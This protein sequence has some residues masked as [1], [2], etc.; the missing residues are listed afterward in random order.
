MGGQT[1]ANSYTVV[2]SYNV[3]VDKTQ[4]ASDMD[5][6]HSSDKTTVLVKSCDYLLFRHTI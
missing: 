6:S 2:N 5:S 4:L 1:T 3:S